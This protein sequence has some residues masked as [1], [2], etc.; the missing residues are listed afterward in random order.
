[1][2]TWGLPTTLNT[3]KFTTQSQIESNN[4]QTPAMAMDKPT[5]VFLT[6][7]LLLLISHSA[8]ITTP[9]TSPPP[10]SPGTCTPDCI[11]TCSQDCI[12]SM[13]RSE[14]KRMFGEP[15]SGNYPGKIPPT[16]PF[17]P[18]ICYQ[19][20]YVDMGYVF[21]L[22]VNDKLLPQC[23]VGLIKYCGRRLTF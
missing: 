8:S 12:I 20:V 22:G 13:M 4:H 3:T 18:K 17:H 7:I 21:E 5:L 23:T 16:Y 1:M 10:E 11:H 19:F 14:C 6:S 2:E 15:I 9:P